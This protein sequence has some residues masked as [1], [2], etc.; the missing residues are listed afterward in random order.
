MVRELMVIDLRQT[1]AAI[2]RDIVARRPAPEISARFHNTLAATIV[3]VCSRIQASDG[4]RRVCLSGG[5]FQNLFLLRR[6]VAELRRRGFE[7]FLHATVPA[8]D[9]GLSLG[10]AV[11]AS[12]LLRIGG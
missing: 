9:G 3:A 8:N 10:Q 4:L 2:V 7:V 11:I 6:T 5:T 1:I 12:E